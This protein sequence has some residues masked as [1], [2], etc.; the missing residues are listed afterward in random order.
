MG[1]LTGHEAE[2]SAWIMDVG[3]IEKTGD[4]R[5]GM[6]ERHLFQDHGLCGL[7]ENYYRTGNGC[8]P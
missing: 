6:V 5:N 7:I 4:D 1:A 8:K 3:Q 2:C